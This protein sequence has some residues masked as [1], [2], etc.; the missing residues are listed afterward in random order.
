M[1]KINA[2]SKRPVQHGFRSHSIW[3]PENLFSDS[4]IVY[5][6]IRRNEKP[7]TKKKLPL[8][9]EFGNVLVPTSKSGVDLQ[10]ALSELI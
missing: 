8:K 3:V 2:T 6:V 10:E 9:S 5:T 7:R 4:K 1:Q